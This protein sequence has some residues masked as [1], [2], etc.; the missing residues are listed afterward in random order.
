ME[1]TDYPAR[2]GV[3]QQIATVMILGWILLLIGVGLF[4]CADPSPDDKALREDTMTRR[5]RDS[6]LGASKLPGA[7]AVQRAL[8]VADSASAR[9]T[10]LDSLIR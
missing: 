3:R 10:P 1:Q 2:S 7:R 6:V 5:H 4:A 8:D 9:T